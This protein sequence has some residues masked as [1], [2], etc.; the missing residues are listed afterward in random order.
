[1]KSTYVHE[2]ERAQENARERENQEKEYEDSCGGRGFACLLTS[3]SP[4]T[5]VLPCLAWYVGVTAITNKKPMQN[6]EPDAYSW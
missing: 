1:M 5:H 6:G 2:H 3:P 4:P